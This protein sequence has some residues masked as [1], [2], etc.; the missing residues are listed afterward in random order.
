MNCYSESIHAKY[1]GDTCYDESVKFLSYALTTPANDSDTEWLIKSGE[2]E[3]DAIQE[4]F[5]DIETKSTSITAAISGGVV[6]SV[7]GSIVGFSAQ[8]LPPYVYLSLAPSIYF[9]VWAIWCSKKARLSAEC[10]KYPSI[11]RNCTNIFE[12]GGK[13]KLAFLA[14]LNIANTI[15]SLVCQEKRRY[16]DK[17]FRK[18][19]LSIAFVG[20][21][22]LAA[23]Y[24]HAI[25]PSNVICV[26]ITRK[27]AE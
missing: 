2:K 1:T 18:L 15:N 12:H 14:Q 17:A 25:K 21:P 22:F 20:L 13:S 26:E 3:Y 23:I 5:N 9:A 16:V 4:D 24:Y 6:A 27:T 11:R 19:F 8:K 7:I 10:C